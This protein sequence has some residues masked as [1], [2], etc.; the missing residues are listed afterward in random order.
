M[1]GRTLVLSV[2]RDDD[3]GYKAGIETPV[4]GRDA[5]IAAASRLGVADPED[6]DTNAIFQA[7]KTYDDE[8]KKGEDVEVAV[9]SGNHMNMLE[10]DKRIAELLEKVIAE[11]GAEKCILISD[12]AEDEYVLPIIQSYMIVTGVVRVTIKQLQNIEGTFYIIKKL[13]NDPKIARA[14]LAPVGVILILY[15]LIALLVPQINALFVAVGAIGVFVLIK[16]LSLDDYVGMVY[17]G[18]VDSLK[19]GHIIAIAYIVC[20]ILIIVGVVSGLISMITYYPNIG[21]VG[22]IY[23]VFTFLYGSIVWI[24]VGS[25]IASIGKIVDCVQNNQKG[26]SR[27]FVFPFFILAA[28]LVSYG[29]VIYFMT[30]SPLEPFPFSTTDGIIAIILL[31][32]A[33]LIVA[34]AGVY[35][36][37][38]VQRRVEAFIDERQKFSEEEKNAKGKPIYRK[39]RY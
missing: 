13:I 35:F 38:M 12:G 20:A 10:G 15:A 32:L 11:T 19:K 23:H 33:G 18:V 1:A 3:V 14:F 21:D 31:T 7:V 28:G 36:R 4:I 2:D 37:P 17:K 29:A 24:V 26:I 5:C 6:S 22:F 39:I 8:V 16:G 34:F 30:I 25:L 9:I 27:I